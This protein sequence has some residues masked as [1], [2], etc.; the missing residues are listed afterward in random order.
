MDAVAYIH[1]RHMVH[2]D[3]KPENIIGSEDGTF[4][5]CD[6]GFSALVG[7]VQG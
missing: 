5:L 7:S 3:I 1:E 4:K 6:F 2:W